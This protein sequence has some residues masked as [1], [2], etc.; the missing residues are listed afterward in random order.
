M[1]CRNQ[2]NSCNLQQLASLRQ[3]MNQLLVQDD[4]Y[5][6]Q[7]D[8]THWYQYGDFNTKFFHTQYRVY[9]TVINI[10]TQVIDINDNMELT[11]SFHIQ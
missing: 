7:R 4:K 3:K 9:Q 11:T 1:F 2:G 10:L 5:C 6:R 8:K